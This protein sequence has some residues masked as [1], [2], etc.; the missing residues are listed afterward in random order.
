MRTSLITVC[1]YSCICFAG[2]FWM[3]Y[4]RSVS[5]SAGAATAPVSFT[6]P[7]HAAEVT[8]LVCPEQHSAYDR[9]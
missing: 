8:T 7:C 4:R 2:K 9:Y 3:A 1:C 6:T 5:S